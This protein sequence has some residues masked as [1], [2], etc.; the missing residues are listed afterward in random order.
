MLDSP[1][2]LTTRQAAKHLGV[3]EATIRR[4]ARTGVITGRRIYDRGQWRYLLDDLERLLEPRE[5]EAGR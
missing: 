4:Y 5:S 1:A 2:M 3:S